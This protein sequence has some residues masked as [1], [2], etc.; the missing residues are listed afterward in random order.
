MTEIWEPC[1][2][3][4]GA[5]YVLCRWLRRVSRIELATARN[6]DANAE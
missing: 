6:D 4:G 3:L 5:L 2:I 1:G